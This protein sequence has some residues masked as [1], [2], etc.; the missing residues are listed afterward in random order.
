MGAFFVTIRN[1]QDNQLK[2]ND[3]STALSHLICLDMV[4]TATSNIGYTKNIDS[5]AF[6]MICFDE[7]IKQAKQVQGVK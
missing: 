1:I 7:Y 6:T 5:G 2:T 3:I 4:K